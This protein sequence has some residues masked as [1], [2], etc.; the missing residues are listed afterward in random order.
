MWW[1]KQA[2]HEEDKTHCD[3]C[4]LSEDETDISY[5]EFVDKLLCDECRNEEER[6]WGERQEFEKWLKE[7]NSPKLKEEVDYKGIREFPIF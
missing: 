1:K 4:G 6:E 5:E 7:Q 3:N 2:Y